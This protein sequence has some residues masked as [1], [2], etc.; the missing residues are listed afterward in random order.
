MTDDGRLERELRLVVRASAPDAAPAHLR[1]RVLAAV[2]APPPR[3]CAAPDGIARP[4]RA[5]S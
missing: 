2:Q 3:S 1:D 5:A 4:P